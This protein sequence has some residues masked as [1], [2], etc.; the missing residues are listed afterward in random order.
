V[1]VVQI[2]RA[3]EQKFDIKRHGKFGTPSTA[4]FAL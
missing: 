2:P 4:M 3:K 1:A